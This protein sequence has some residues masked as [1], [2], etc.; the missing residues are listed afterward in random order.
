MLTTFVIGLREGLEASLI[1]GIVAAFLRQE[2]RRDA[3]RYMWAGVA[4]AV[5]LCLAVGVG[6]SC[7]D[8]SSRS[9]QQ[10]GLETVVGAGRR[11]DGHV[12]DRLDAQPR[13]RAA[14]AS[15]RPRRRRARARLG[16][17]LVGDGVPRRAARGLRDRRLPARRLPGRHRPDRRAASAPCSASLRRGRDR[18]RHLPR[19]RAAQP[20][21]L[22]PPHRRR[23]RARRRR[24]RRPSRCTRR[25]RPAGSTAPGRRRSTSSWLV[26]PGTV[27]ASLVT[28]MLGLQPQPTVAEVAGLP[29]LRG[30]DADLRPLARPR[31]AL[32]RER[33]RVRPATSR[34]RPL[35]RSCCAASACCERRRRGAAHRGTLTAPRARNEVSGRRSPTPAASRR[36][37]RA[38]RPARPR[39]RSTNTAPRR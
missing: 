38:R 35:R 18:L 5:V 6:L 9:A 36:S 32:R 8:A 29:A 4:L 19:R 14:R 31:S 30:A 22:L 16:V 7:V 24:P 15:S 17:A 39:S 11:R 26:E 13:P 12:H 23:A 10:E 21:A 1:V 20:R 3:L 37:A 33:A 34:R 2:G 28:G 27:S 25:T